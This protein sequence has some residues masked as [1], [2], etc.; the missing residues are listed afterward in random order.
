MVCGDNGDTVDDIKNLQLEN[1]LYSDFV[2]KKCIK[3]EIIM[4]SIF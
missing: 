2:F 1:S 3:S 4:K